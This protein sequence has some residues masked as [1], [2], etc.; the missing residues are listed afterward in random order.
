MSRRVR[1]CIPAAAMALRRRAY[2]RATAGVSSRSINLLLD[3]SL[4]MIRQHEYS[5]WLDV[6]L[7][8]RHLLEH[9][10]IA[11]AESMSDPAIQARTQT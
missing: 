9:K 7:P 10:A 11:A 8:V 6:M 3:L 2:R 1:A 5:A 4:S